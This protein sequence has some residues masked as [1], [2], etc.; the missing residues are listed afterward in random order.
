MLKSH[1]LEALK[2]II[3]I[4]AS[5]SREFSLMHVDVSSAYFHAKGQRLV[6][7]ILPA[8]D[9][10]GK[11]EG[12]I[13]LLKKNMYG[14][15]DAASNWERDLE[16]WGHELGRS[17]RNL[18]HN[19]KRK[20]SVLRHGDDFVVTGTKGSLE[21]VY[22]IKASIIGAGST[23]SMQAL[24]RRICW[25]ETGISYQH[26]P[27]HVD[28][29]VESLGLENGNTVQTPMIDDVK[30]ENPVWLDSEQISKYRSHV[31][32]CLFSSQS[33]AD[34]TFAVNKLC[35]RTSDPSQNNTAFPN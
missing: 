35:Q 5:H 15:R 4:A 7:V 32:R 16:N 17:S 31:A 14:T 12:K 23:K 19:K 33:R 20:T 27:R 30:D 18:F 28:V 9:F 10:S 2:A 8:E 29:L 26:D 11:D 6:P 13:G 24:N 25:E 3:S 34:I 21:S 22:P 1:P